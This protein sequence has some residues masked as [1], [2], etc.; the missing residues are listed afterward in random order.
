MG[1]ASCNCVQMKTSDEVSDPK[2]LKDKIIIR[3]KPKVLTN[4]QDDSNLPQNLSI[5]GEFLKKLPKGV[6][7]INES[8]SVSFNLQ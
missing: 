4:I 1:A 6:L 7:I 5:E 2:P 8:N 3:E